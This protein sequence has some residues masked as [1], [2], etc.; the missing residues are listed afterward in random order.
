MS[1][2]LIAR[3]E[4]TESRWLQG[5]FW[6]ALNMFFQLELHSLYTVNEF[7]GAQSFS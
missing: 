5:S 2:K 4:E 7:F 3:A 1:I 6:T